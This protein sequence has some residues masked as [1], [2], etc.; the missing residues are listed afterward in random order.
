[1]ADFPIDFF[2][3]LDDQ[4]KSFIECATN[5]RLFSEDNRE[6]INKKIDFL[7]VETGE[8]VDISQERLAFLKRLLNKVEVLLDNDSALIAIAEFKFSFVD[9]HANFYEIKLDL[10]DQL[11]Y[12]KHKIKKFIYTHTVEDQ[13]TLVEENS[14]EAE[15]ILS[16]NFIKEFAN[17]EFEG[18]EL[19]Q[20][21]D[22]ENLRNNI[23]L[24]IS[25]K[26]DEINPEL[27]LNVKKSYLGYYII[28]EILD[29]IKSDYQLSPT[30]KINGAAY[31]SK[32][33]SEAITKNFSDSSQDNK[34]S[35]MI[36]SLKKQILD[37]I[38]HNKVQ[39]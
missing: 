16:S 8:L 11:K 34:K 30:V 2:S 35:K 1:M 4:I 36:E 28:T 27:D 31:T 17:F 10:T 38:N 13:K 29:F 7:K 6:I 15:F 20:D 19:F 26:S 14:S 5:A 25:K 23:F 32:A 22:R 12:Y 24:L 21:E 33:R 9:L 18:I 3:E 37:L 39:D